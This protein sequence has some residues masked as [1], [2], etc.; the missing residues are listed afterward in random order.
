MVQTRGAIVSR[1]FFMDCAHT[2]LMHLKLDFF[3]QLIRG[4]MGLGIPI[5][6]YS[7]PRGGDAAYVQ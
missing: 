3:L 2:R 6:F 1:R 4:L 5:F 7:T